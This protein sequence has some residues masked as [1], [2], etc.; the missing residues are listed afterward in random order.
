[1]STALQ[2]ALNFVRTVE[3]DEDVVIS[4]SFVI[5]LL[6]KITLFWGHGKTPGRENCWLAMK[7]DSG[8]LCLHS[9]TFML[10]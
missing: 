8:F 4:R 7:S 3:Q 10:I 6:L 9:F 2:L 5:L 1:M